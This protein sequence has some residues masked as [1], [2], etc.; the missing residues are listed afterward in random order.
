MMEDS[1]HF[2]IRGPKVSVNP[3]VNLRADTD[4]RMLTAEVCLLLQQTEVG[5]TD[6][7]LLLPRKFDLRCGCLRGRC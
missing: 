7:V 3:Y 1:I 5:N 4:A 2:P 6:T